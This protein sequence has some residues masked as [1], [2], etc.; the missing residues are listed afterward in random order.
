MTLEVMGKTGEVACNKSWHKKM[1]YKF[2]SLLKDR[3]MKL[4]FYL[5]FT[6]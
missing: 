2:Q 5:K 3:K 6:E 4:R 1:E